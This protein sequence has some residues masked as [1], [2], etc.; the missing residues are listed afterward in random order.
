MVS[1]GT[2]LCAVLRL[3]WVVAAWC[4][5]GAGVCCLS[6]VRGGLF[7]HGWCWAMLADVRKM[8]E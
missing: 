1:L 2:A 8:L 3:V 5:C 6:A 4:W 7:R